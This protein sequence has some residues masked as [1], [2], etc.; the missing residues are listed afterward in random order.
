M[1]EKDNFV[2]IPKKYIRSQVSRPSIPTMFQQG[3]IP[4]QH[5]MS[6][7][8]MRKFQS[9]HLV[10]FE[11]QKIISTQPLPVPIAILKETEREPIFLSSH[12]NYSAC[13][14]RNPSAGMYTS[15]NTNVVQPSM[16]QEGIEGTL[17]ISKIPMT[18]PMQL[19]YNYLSS[20][21]KG[22]YAIMDHFHVGRPFQFGPLDFPNR[23]FISKQ[24]NL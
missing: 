13:N 24:P 18:N 19:P 6:E 16:S 3:F 14:F 17:H 9:K 8:K 1:I 12:R 4:S 22:H 2:D 11:N 21:G 5:T 15:R 10:G 20:D 23:T 7:D